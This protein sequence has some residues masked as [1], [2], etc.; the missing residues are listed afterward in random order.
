MSIFPEVL[1]NR[2]FENA[3]EPY[4]DVGYDEK[5]VNIPY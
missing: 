3:P 4:Q 2:G 1:E 5:V